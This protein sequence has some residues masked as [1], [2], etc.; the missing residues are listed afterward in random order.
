MIRAGDWVIVVRR[1]G[2]DGSARHLGHIFRAVGVEYWPT[3]ECWTCGRRHSVGIAVL[4]GND[5]GW[6]IWRLQRIGPKSRKAACVQKE[7]A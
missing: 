7:A 5:H 6:P 4:E 1:S 2:C 3:A